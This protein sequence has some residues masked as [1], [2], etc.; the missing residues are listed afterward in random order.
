M[1]PARLPLPRR[2]MASSTRPVFLFGV[3]DDGACK[4]EIKAPVHIQWIV[5]VLHL[6]R[7]PSSDIR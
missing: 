7:L 6:A 3:Q 4:V 5:V 2:A 1:P